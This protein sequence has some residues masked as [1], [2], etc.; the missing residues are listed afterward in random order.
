MNKNDY[1]FSITV[2]DPN[3]QTYYIFVKKSSMLN[4]KVRVGI[5]HGDF[6]GIGYEVIFKT[7][8]DSRIYELCT[9]IVY[10][11]SKIASYHRKT[12]NL[13]PDFSFNLIKKADQASSKKA[14]IINCSEK[15]AKIELGKPDIIAGDYAF[16]ALESA[17]ED[18]KTNQIDVVVTAPINKK[19]IQS[20]EFK[21]PGHTEYF[22]EK[23]NTP[24]Y[25]MLMVSG[26]LRIGVITGHIP[27][28]L[29]SQTITMELILQK[30]KILNKSLIEDFGIQ[31][32]KIA[33][34]GINPHAGDEGVIGNEDQEI[35]APAIKAAFESGKMVFGP[36]P[37]DGFFGNMEQNKFDA[38]LAMYH[39]Q[40]LIPFKTLA[41]DE[42][43]NFTAGLPIVRTSPGHGTAF[44]IAG[45]DIAKP[46]SFRAA[47][48]LAIDIFTN[49]QDYAE[50]KAN[51]LKSYLSGKEEEGQIS[52]LTEE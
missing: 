5:T 10:G 28:S 47:L 42:G 39:D 17:T 24:D 6:N 30:I 33:V 48:Y 20:K 15:E 51:P 13:P 26:N 2:S 31:K 40:G 12:V 4:Q 7:L 1:F 41:F 23:F 37:A 38:V 8:R 3:T 25:L 34:L 16:W 19:S 22:A 29:V 21:F 32:P 50:L 14:N 44:K 45:Q 46:D 18:L 49:R 52:D 35:V 27:L 11:N 36:Y 43:V 9:P